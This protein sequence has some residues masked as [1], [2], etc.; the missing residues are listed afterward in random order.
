MLFAAIIVIVAAL[1]AVAAAPAI[2]CAQ[3]KTRVITK[4]VITGALTK[5]PVMA[6]DKAMARGIAI[7]TSPQP[8]SCW[9]ETKH[10]WFSFRGRR[11]PIVSSRRMS[12]PTARH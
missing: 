6:F 10:H 12:Q 7:A 11:T 9:L 1:C 5:S 2:A 4:N 8:V 3:G